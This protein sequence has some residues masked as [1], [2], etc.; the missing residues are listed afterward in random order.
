MSFQPKRD[1]EIAA[2]LKR[3]R[4][5]YEAPEIAGKDPEWLAIDRILD[6][7]RARADYGKSLTDSL[8]GLY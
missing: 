1:D 4:D 2:W 5:T 6:E 3:K 7:Y 8:D